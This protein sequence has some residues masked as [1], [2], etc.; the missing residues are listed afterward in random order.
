MR[1]LTQQ[2]LEE[3]FL[4]PAL[5]TLDLKLFWTISHWA[6]AHAG[7]ELLTALHRVRRQIR[8]MSM[9]VEKT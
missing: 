9:F 5:E 6:R 3:V 4:A 1:K 7:I 2:E 8:E